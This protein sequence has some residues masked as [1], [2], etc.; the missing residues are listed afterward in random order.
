ME[1]KRDYYLNK[2]ITKKHNGLIKVITGI[3]RCGKSY[4]LFTLFKNHLTESGVADD[5]IVEIPFDSF[6]NKKYRDPEILYPYVK[7]QIA[8]DGMYYIL[9]DEVQLLGEFESVLNG[10]MRMKNVDVYVT[11]SNARFLS[12]DII[13]EFRG[14]GDELHIQPLSFAEFMSV[15]DGNKYDGWNEYVLYGG[16]PPVVLLR[17]AEQK[18]ELLKSLFQETYINDIISRHSVKHRDEFEELINILASAIGSLTNPK[19]LTDT[20]KSKKNKVISSNT[21]KSYLDYLCDAYVVSR[22][23]RYD[24][25]GKKYIDTP[26]KYYFSDVGIRN[27]C[28]NFRQLEENHTMENIIYNELIAR[29]FNVDVGIITATGKDNDGKSVRK[30]LEVDFVCNKGSKR[31]YIQSAFSIP[32]REKMEQESNSLLRIDDSFKK[33]IVVKDL[34]APTYTEDGILVISV[35]DFLLN[36]NSLD[37]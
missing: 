13:T 28:I 5:H 27:A 18:I 1:I 17:T 24:I 35:Y 33:I 16:L 3:R 7:E 21:I 36:S 32:D 20:F 29:N 26:Q 37:M 19:K 12:K 34:P 2:L 23:T 9:L 11:G 25:K 10:F 31:Y 22:A 14:R 30:Q 6:E 4:L 15:Y 8:D